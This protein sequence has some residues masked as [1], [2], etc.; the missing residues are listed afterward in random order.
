MS[1]FITKQWAHVMQPALLIRLG[2]YVG[3]LT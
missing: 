1:L 3:S 2:H